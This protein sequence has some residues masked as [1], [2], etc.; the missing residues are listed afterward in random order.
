M[1]SNIY[2]ID[3]RRRRTV[4]ER[5]LSE[6]VSGAVNEFKEFAETRIAM[7]RS[8]L[9]EKSQQIKFA[10]P[11]LVIGALLG[12]SAWFVLTGALVAV[13]AA[14][15]GDWIWGPFLAL[16]I[17]GVV[18][19]IGAACAMWMGYSRLTANGLM[20]ERTLQV[21]KEDKVFLQNEA[22]TQL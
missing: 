21:L 3:E 15:F 18:Y 13:I 20:P 14:A 2:N 1:S 6:T 12:V 19:L 17:V 7:L 16:I 22:R 11:L 8:E 5:P 9:R 10:A 4:Q